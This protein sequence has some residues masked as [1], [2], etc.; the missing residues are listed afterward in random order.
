[1]R[2]EGVHG[3]ALA[4]AKKFK[5]VRD[6]WNGFNVLHFA[7]ARMGG[8]MLGYAHDGG[9]KKLA[10]ASPKLAFFLGADE[11]DYSLFGKTSKSMSATMATMARIMPTSFC[12][13]QPIPRNRAHM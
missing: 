2:Y 5:L 10:A 7:A 12:Q 11:V 3:A 9:I 6:G 8:L 4:F 1:M 13:A